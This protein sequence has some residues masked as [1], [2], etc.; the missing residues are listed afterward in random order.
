MPAFARAF[1]CYKKS[2]CICKQK[3]DVSSKYKL[4]TQTEN[5]NTDANGK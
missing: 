3:E 4:Q 1:G 5:T 2:R